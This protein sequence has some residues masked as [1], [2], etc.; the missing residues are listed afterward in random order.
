MRLCTLLDFEDLIRDTAMGLAVNSRG[1]LFVRRL[2]ET[3]DRAFCFVIPIAQ[4]FDPMLVL[5]R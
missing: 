5:D 1:R 4:I 2:T 3:E